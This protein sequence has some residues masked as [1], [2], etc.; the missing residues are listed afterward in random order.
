MPR[1]HTLFALTATIVALAPVHAAEVTDRVD[2]PVSLDV[3]VDPIAYALGGYSVHAGLRRGAFRLDLGAFA[4]E[5]PEAFHGS[6][7]FEQ[8]SGGFGIK[9]DYHPFERLPGLLFGGQITSM[10]EQVRH[11]ETGISKSE[12]YLTL[13]GRVG[14][15][16]GLPGGFYLLPWFGADVFMRARST[17]IAGATHA[18]GRVLFFPTVHFGYTL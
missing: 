13:G 14:Y 18:P 8:Y 3:E 4:A 7:G 16:I 5:V 12:R 10:R 2:A 1:T 9:V 11:T 6:K 17:T 15:E